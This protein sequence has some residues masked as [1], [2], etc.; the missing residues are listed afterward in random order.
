MLTSVSVRLTSMCVRGTATGTCG[1]GIDCPEGRMQNVNTHLRW[2]GTGGVGG[3][4]TDGMDRWDSM[5]EKESEWDWRSG[6][7]RQRGWPWRDGWIV[8]ENYDETKKNDKMFEDR[9]GMDGDGTQQEL[10]HFLIN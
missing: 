1:V 7:A 2:G 3:W 6:N 9:D 8:E 10:I 5:K 4:E